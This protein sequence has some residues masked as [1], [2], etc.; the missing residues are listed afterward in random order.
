MARRAARTRPRSIAWPLLVP[1][2]VFGLAAGHDLAYRLT[3]PGEHARRHELALAGHGYLAYLPLVLGICFALLAVAFGVRVFALVRR[4]T[5]RTTPAGLFAAL[6][7]LAFALQE[8]LERFVQLG[9]FPTELVTD[10][11]FLV[12]LLLQVPFALAALVLA[13][14]CDSLARGLAAAL[15]GVR[16]SPGFAPFVARFATACSRPR[17]HPLA[18]AYSERGPPRIS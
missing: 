9:R 11:T 17:L 15:V 6:P 16:P 18:L 14:A 8:H 3:V 2:L 13:R 4:R 12:G 10:P 5:L 1:L 7:P